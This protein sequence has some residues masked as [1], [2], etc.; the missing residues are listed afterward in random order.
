MPIW[1][2]PLDEGDTHSSSAFWR[3]SLTISVRKMHSDA[4]RFLGSQFLVS[5][6]LIALRK[7]A[8]D[9]HMDLFLAH[10]KY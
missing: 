5:T 2:K 3:K 6:G 1:V 7:T 8:T 10:T 4:D 9:H